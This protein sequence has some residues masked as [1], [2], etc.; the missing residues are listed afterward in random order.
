MI[1]RE[2]RGRANQLRGNAYPKHF[3]T[4][5]LPQLRRLKGFRGAVLA[6]RRVA[7]SIEFVV[8]TRWESL[9]SI[10]SFAGPDIER[11]VVEPDAVAALVEFDARVHHYEVIE[12]VIDQE[13][14]ERQAS[15]C[16]P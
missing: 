15:P 6:K 9:D 1:I 14:P 11:A 13:L 3:R 10:R 2:W 8:L 12:E 16:A 7:G 4:A 5:V